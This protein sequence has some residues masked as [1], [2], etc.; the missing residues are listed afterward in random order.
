MVSHVELYEDKPLASDKG[1]SED[2]EEEVDANGSTPAVLE[3][4]FEW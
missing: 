2:E 3:A 4:R 1:D